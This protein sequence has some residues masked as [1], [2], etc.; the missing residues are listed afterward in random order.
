[1]IVNVS[2]TASACP[3]AQALLHNY[4]LKDVKNN[5]NTLPGTDSSL[6]AA[7]HS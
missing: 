1:M 3:W 7:V 4:H 6:Q 2:T 5:R